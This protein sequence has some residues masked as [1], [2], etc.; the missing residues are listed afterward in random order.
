MALEV[1]RA[2]GVTAIG[3]MAGR[4]PIH[5]SY[6]A[7]EDGG[8]LNLKVMLTVGM[9]TEGRHGDGTWEANANPLSR[10]WKITTL[11]SSMR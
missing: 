11:I 2:N 4:E 8:E 5:E 1:V 9:F 6:K 10:Q 7:L 3:D